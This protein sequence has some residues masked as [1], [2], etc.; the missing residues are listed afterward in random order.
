MMIKIYGIQPALK[1]LNGI[2]RDIRV[3]WALEELNIPY[4]HILLDPTKGE[5]KTPEYLKLNP[6]GKIPTLTDGEFSIFESSAICSYLAHK[7]KMLLPKNESRDYW[8]HQQWISYILTNIEPHTAR[9][10]GCDH[11]YEQ[12]ENTAFARKL[13]TDVLTR[14]IVPL[15]DKLGQNKY[16]MGDNFLLADLLLVTC[17]MYVRH[18][19]ILQSYPNLK[20]HSNDCANRPAYLK[21]TK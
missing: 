14:M 9:V 8:I 4:E 19:E 5:N 12:N 1:E 13:A 11:F 6:T 7:E 3:T 21:A 16:L 10:F 2:T 17:L 18:T 20:R 15:E